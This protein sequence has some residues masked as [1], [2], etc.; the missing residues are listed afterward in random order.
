MTF[1]E[2]K[3]VK[4]VGDVYE[5]YNTGTTTNAYVQTTF[6][7]KVDCLTISNDSATDPIQYSYDGAILEGNLLANENITVYVKSK[8]SIWLKG[9]AG[10]GT[11]R[12]FS[13]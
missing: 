6:P 3:R 4:S 5:F 13:W 12:V 8:G 10:G 7:A 11:Y 2:T 1:D 9:T